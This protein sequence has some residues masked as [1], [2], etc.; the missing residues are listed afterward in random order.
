LRKAV[1][2]ALASL[3][4]ALGIIGVLLP[5]LPTTPFLLLSSYFAARSSP[6]FHNFL[7]RS[8]LIGP[9]LRD[10]QEHKGIRPHV[11]WQA[12]ALVGIALAILAYTAPLPA[13]AQGIVFLLGFVGLCVI[14]RLPTIS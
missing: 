8:K 13:V 9:I 6:R 11:K 2:I 14:W 10:W 3:F 7:L 5:G 1:Y 12:T 4:L